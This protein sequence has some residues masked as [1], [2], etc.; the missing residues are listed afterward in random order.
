MHFFAFFSHARTTRSQASQ[1]GAENVLATHY[2]M[3]LSR[4]PCYLIFKLTGCPNIIFHT[5]IIFLLL[6]PKR[7]RNVTYY[8]TNNHTIKYLLGGLRV[9]LHSI[10]CTFLYLCVPFV[11]LCPLCTFACLFVP[12]VPICTFC[13][14]LYLFVIFCTFQNINVARF[15]LTVVK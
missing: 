10:F 6:L 1:A 12:F 14:F 11:Y 9:Q 5:V 2:K 8:R 13:T 15:A 4:V 3:V 7:L